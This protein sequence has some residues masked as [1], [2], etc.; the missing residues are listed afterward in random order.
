MSPEQA[1]GKAGRQANRYLVVWC[2]AVGYVDGPAV[3]LTVETVS[4]VL[5]AVLTK[6]PDWTMLP[7][8]DSSA[9]P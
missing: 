2:R 5:A 4:H 3:S 6:A 7:G 9:D 8:A 1:A